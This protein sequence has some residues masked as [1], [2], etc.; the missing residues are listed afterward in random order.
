MSRFPATA[1]GRHNR[2]YTVFEIRT[3]LGEL[4]FESERV[5]TADVSPEP[6]D[7][8]SWFS[9]LE[10]SDR[11]EYVFAVARAFGSDRWRFPEWLYQSRQALWQVVLPDMEVGRDDDLQT[12]G[13][14]DRDRVDDRDV[15]WMGK[16]T[17][18]RVLLSPRFEGP[19]VLRIEGLSPPI[20]FGQPVSLHA[21]VG[22]VEL[23]HEILS[24]SDWFSLAFPVRVIRGDQEVFLRTDR[25]WR[26]FDL[27]MSVDDR[28][29]SVGICAVGFEPGAE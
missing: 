27:G 21:R 2:E 22:D 29:L 1:Y 18:A 25:T 13:F 23:S 7:A 11:G 24:G 12:D 15:R 8:V 3:L 28:E 6:P 17:E 26:P 19:G 20:E 16:K 14:H 9:G 4:G 5:F 10:L